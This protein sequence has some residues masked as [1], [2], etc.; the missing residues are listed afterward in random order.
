MLTDSSPSRNRR[1]YEYEIWSVISFYDVQI[2]LERIFESSHFK[3]V[4][5]AKKKILRFEIETE[6]FKWFPLKLIIIIL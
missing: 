3:E 5:E 4:L 1:S 2:H 6:I